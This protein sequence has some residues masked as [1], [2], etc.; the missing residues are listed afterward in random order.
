VVLDAVG[1]FL[2]AYTALFFLGKNLTTYN[3]SFI[4][5]I[6]SAENHFSKKGYRFS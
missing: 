2:K 5:S 6:S 1:N 4:V 3:H